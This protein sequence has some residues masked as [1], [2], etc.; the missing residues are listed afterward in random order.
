MA[1][2]LIGAYEG[3]EHISLDVSGVYLQTEMSADKLVLLMKFKGKM[4]E[5]LCG[6]NPEYSKYLRK[7]NGVTV[8]YVKVIRAIYGC[9]ESALQWYK[10]FTGILKDMV[11]ELNPYDTCVVNRMVNGK[12]LTIVWHVDDCISSHMEKAVLEELGK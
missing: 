9:I 11:F 12:Q 3:R 2:L 10:L 5:M 4:A 6:V 1:T 7:E 8:L